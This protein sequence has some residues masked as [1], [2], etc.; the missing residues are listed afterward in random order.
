MFE[1]PAHNQSDLKIECDAEY[2]GGTIGSTEGAMSFISQ[3]T[4]FVFISKTKQAISPLMDIFFMCG[5][6]KLFSATPAEQIFFKSSPAFLM[7]SPWQVTGSWPIHFWLKINVALTYEI[8][9]YVSLISVM[10]VT[11]I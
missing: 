7:V 9:S 3:Q 2:E 5:E 10:S 8:R 6:N 11:P 4:S 1:R